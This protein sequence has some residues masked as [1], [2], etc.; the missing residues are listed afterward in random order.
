MTEM[1]VTAGFNGAA[2]TDQFS[3]T[4]AFGVKDLF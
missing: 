1:S 2:G 4:P 3:L